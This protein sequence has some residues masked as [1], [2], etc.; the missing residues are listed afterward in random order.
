MSVYN[1]SCVNLRRRQ[2]TVVTGFKHRLSR[3]TKPFIVCSRMLL[4]WKGNVTG[5][6]AR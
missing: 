4:P 5:I 1:T 6:I 3:K 2:L